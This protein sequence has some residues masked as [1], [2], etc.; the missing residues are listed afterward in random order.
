M[1]MR[2]GYEET[3]PVQHACAREAVDST[4]GQYSVTLL[5]ARIL[6]AQKADAAAFVWTLTGIKVSPLGGGGEFFI[7]RTGTLVGKILKRSL[8]RYQDPVL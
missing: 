8:K 2:F 5:T 1:L 6:H 7:R 4:A 3:S